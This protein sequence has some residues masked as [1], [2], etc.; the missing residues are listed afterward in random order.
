MDT[1]YLVFD[2]GGRS[3]AMAELMRRDGNEAKLIRGI[4]DVV[5]AHSEGKMLAAVLPMPLYDENG[6]LTAAGFDEEELLKALCFADITVGGRINAQFAERA[7]K[8]GIVM[9]DY[10]TR[11]EFT[12]SNALTTAEAAVGIAMRELRTTISGTAA[13]VIGYGRIGRCLAKLLKAMG[14]EVTVSARK[15]ADLM[16]I[17]TE[18]YECA[19]TRALTGLGR[20]SVVFNTAP[21]PVFGRAEISETAADAVLIDLASLPGGMDSESADILGRRVI[22]ALSLPGKYAPET[23]AKSACTAIYAVISEENYG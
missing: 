5:S 3:R 16:W 14:A 11:D 23:A 10:S 20:Y 6:A 21:A 1:L 13:L 18:G 2:G 22:R 8:L 19:D 12:I 7:E 17:R 4:S 15:T 9:R